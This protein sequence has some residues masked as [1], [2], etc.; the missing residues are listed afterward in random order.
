MN[1]RGLR[2]RLRGAVSVEYA[3]IL[4]ALLLFILGLFDTGRLLWT[5]TTLNRAAES[6]ARCAAINTAACGT[7]AQVQNFAVNE[8]WG[9]TIDASAF[10]VSAPACGIQ[11]Q[12][13]Y[14]FTFVIPGLA[15]F[16]PLGT[17]SLKAT[18]CYPVAP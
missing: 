12:G 6:A 18:A 10:S 2:K 1:M 3:L 17:I 15:A 4:P 16:T 5:Y 11:V 13:A 14:D 7:A 9:L 8:A